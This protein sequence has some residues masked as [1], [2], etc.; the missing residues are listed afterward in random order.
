MGLVTLHVD[1]LRQRVGNL[2]VQEVQG[3]GSIVRIP[4]VALPDGWNKRQTQVT[5]VAPEGYPF[6]KPD[7]FW[8]DDD[9]RLA[10][11]ALPQNSQLNNPIPGAPGNCLWFSWHVEP[12][13]PNQDDLVTW[14]TLIKQ[15]LAK[16]Q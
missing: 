9:L 1:R 7:C 14:F 5:L 11:G 15:R 13:N 10:N 8:T 12:W 6:A 2:H 16:P 4:D 3:S